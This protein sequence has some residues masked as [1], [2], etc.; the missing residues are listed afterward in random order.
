LL[1]GLDLTYVVDDGI[2]SITTTDA[3]YPWL[4]YKNLRWLAAV[5]AAF[6][7]GIRFART[8][9]RADAKSQVQLP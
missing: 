2:M 1:N 6:V 7:V 9:W 8:W 3:A 4:L 5:V